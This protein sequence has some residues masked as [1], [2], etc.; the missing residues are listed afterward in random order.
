MSFFKFNCL[1]DL[2]LFLNP[3]LNIM[4]FLGFSHSWCEGG[5]ERRWNRIW[6]C[7][8]KCP[9]I[10]FRKSLFETEY[11]SQSSSI[12]I[13]V[14]IMMAFGSGVLL[15]AK[16]LH[17]HSH[18]YRFYNSLGNHFFLYGLCSCCP[19]MM[20]LFHYCHSAFANLRYQSNKNSF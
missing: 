4:H 15:F 10:R 7:F 3:F 1:Y 8:K 19:T 16:V 14:Y 18:A 5:G 13:D 11:Y 17:L 9:K 20:P 12:Y 6:F 2:I